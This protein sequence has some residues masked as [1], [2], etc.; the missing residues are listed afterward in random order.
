ML[1]RGFDRFTLTL[2]ECT[3]LFEAHGVI[4]LEN[5][6]HGSIDLKLGEVVSFNSKQLSAWNGSYK[7]L[8]EDIDGFCASGY[9]GVFWQELK[10]RQKSC[11]KP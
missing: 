10:R 8:R 9:S 11:A 2:N 7:Q 3:E 4:L 1:C 5:F 6:I